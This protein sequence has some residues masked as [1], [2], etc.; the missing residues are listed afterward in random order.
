ME[1]DEIARGI[2]VFYN[3]NI[4]EKY[5]FMD[6]PCC[7]WYHAACGGLPDTMRVLKNIALD[8]FP[9]LVQVQRVRALMLWRTPDGQNALQGAHYHLDYRLRHIETLHVSRENMCSQRMYV[10]QIKKMYAG[11]FALIA[12]LRQTFLPTDPLPSD[13]DMLW[14]YRYTH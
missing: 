4:L 7:N 9:P 13:E 12:E 1:D 6:Q 2:K 10:A 3:L 11:V 5:P 14:V 8:G